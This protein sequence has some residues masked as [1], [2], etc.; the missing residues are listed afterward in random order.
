MWNS[1]YSMRIRIV[2]QPNG[3][4]SGIALDRYLIGRVYD[5]GSGIADYLVT[6]GF[7]IVEMRVQDR[8][9]SPGKAPPK[10]RKR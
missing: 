6:E 8:A 9:D 1:S 7:A 10:P 5:L 2:K 3:T 4:V